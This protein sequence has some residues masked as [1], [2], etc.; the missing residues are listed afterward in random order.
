MT[1]R[2]VPLKR[3]LVTGGAGFIGSHLVER[4]LSRN[5]EVYVLDNLST[6]AIRNL[7]AVRHSPKLH[8][9]MD[10][11]NNGALLT[12]LV[13]RA[14][15]VFH[16]AAAVGV[17][18]IVQDPVRTIET[19]IHGTEV[20]LQ[21]CA[22]KR[23]KIVLASTSEVY[24]KG[25][26]RLFSEEDNLVFGPTT[27]PRWSYG[28]S[29]AIDEFLALAYHNAKGVPVIITRFF[30]IVGPRQ[31]GMY[32]MVVPRFVRQALQGG[33]ITVY[34]DGEQ[35]RSFTHIYDL[36]DGV[37]ALVDTDAAVGQ[38]FNV[39]SNQPVSIN[40]LAEKVREMINPDAEIVHIPYG[41]AYAEGFEDIRYRVPDT[42]KLRKAIGFE[43]KHDLEAILRDV[44]DYISVQTGL[45]YL[46][47]S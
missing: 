32:G 24:G 27:K 46:G 11:I 8:L 4:L 45:E 12:E 38:I 3:A 10:D 20:V 40:G 28:C 14:D 7:D 29:K 25:E 43:P 33:P 31:V 17:K 15:V 13:D 30:N 26:S 21:R 23:T 1:V 9:Y 2:S 16:L 35:V 42:A 22:N 6:G 36:V 18:L 47:E 5:V 41:E 37:L 44:R 19:N 39:G 34:G